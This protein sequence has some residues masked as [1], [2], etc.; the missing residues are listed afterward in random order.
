MFD[1]IYLLFA[2]QQSSNQN[3]EMCVAEIAFFSM[4]MWIPS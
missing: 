1:E 3:R 4:R 2:L